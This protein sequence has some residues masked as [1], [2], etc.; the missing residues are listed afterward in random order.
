MSDQVTRG[1]ID[2][3][4]FDIDGTLLSQKT[5]KVPLGTRKAIAALRARGIKV[6][7]AT[8]R[9]P[10]ELPGAGLNDMAFDGFAAANGQMCLDAN[11]RLFAGF[12]IQDEG[13]QALVS[14]FEQNEL[15]VWFFGESA[16]YANRSTELLV[17]LSEAI[18]G[19]APMV[20]PYDGSTIYQAVVLAGP[21]TDEQIQA[22]LPGCLLQRWGAEGADIIAQG[23]GK[24]EGMKRFFERFGCTQE[25]SMAFGDELNDLD[26]LRFAGIGVAMGNAAPDVKA[27]A[28]Y[29]TLSVDEDGIAHALEYFGVLEA[30]WDDQGDSC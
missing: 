20:H 11:Q 3:V 19:T 26:M 8:G 4:F 13:T 16:C 7:V 22:L 29:E 27:A 12:P 17:T 18:S 28:D 30:G 1:L 10:I 25:R 5:G 15:V 2:I 21:E 14:L 23:G 9:H 6:V 24:V